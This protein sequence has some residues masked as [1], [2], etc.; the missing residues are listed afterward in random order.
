[1]SFAPDDSDIRA[2]SCTITSRDDF[3]RKLQ[4][5]AADHDTHI[6]CFNADKIAGRA[7]AAIAVKLASRAFL[8]G[9]NISN[10]LEMETLLYTAG[11]RQCNIAASFGIHEGENQL[12]ICCLPV[13]N[14]CW[15]AL[16]QLFLFTDDDRDRI[17]P[18]RLERLMEIFAVSPEELD[19]AG[20]DA[21]ILDLVLERVALLQV[22]R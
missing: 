13:R 20:G 7:H 18:E 14:G 6:I 10:T 9:T 19:A 1:M 4:G 8:E 21:R 15:A 11:S 3:L 17:D 5:I 2:A 16:E 12:W 22:L